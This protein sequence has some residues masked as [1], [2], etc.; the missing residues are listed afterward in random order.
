MHQLIPLMLV[1]SGNV[2]IRQWAVCCVDDMI[3]FTSPHCGAQYMKT[4]V[5]CLTVGLNDQAPEVRQ[6]AAYGLGVAAQV[7]PEIFTTL[8]LGRLYFF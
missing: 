1:E 5:E 8:C 7:G 6:A 4:I 2:A 3:E